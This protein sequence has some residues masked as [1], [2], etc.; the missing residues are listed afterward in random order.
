MKIGILTL[1]D[2]NDNF[3][4][5]LQAWSLK[6]AVTQISP[7]IESGVIPLVYDDQTEIR[8]FKK[9]PQNVSV[10]TDLRR[11]LSRLCRNFKRGIHIKTATVRSNKF[12]DFFKQNSS[13]SMP[14]I[15]AKDFVG[16]ELDIDIFIVGSDWVWHIPERYLNAQPCS[17]GIEYKSV[18]LGFFPLKQNQKL[19]A[20]AASQGIIP[21]IRSSLFEKALDNFATVS[22]REEESIPYLKGCNSNKEITKVV[23]PTLLLKREDFLMILSQPKEVDYIAV[24]CLPFAFREQFREY[25]VNLQNRINKQIIILNMP[26][27]FSIP[28][29]RCVGN[30]IGPREFLGYISGASYLVTNSFHGMVF[31]S[32]FHTKF[33][34]FRRQQQDYRQD[35]LA[36]MLKLEQR[37]LDAGSTIT[38]D[39]DPF[40]KTI[41]WSICDNLRNQINKS[42]WDFLKSS[43]V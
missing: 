27:E 32:I 22:V 2:K 29:C 39:N 18:L 7:T 3:G 40:F 12:N 33:T 36:K 24:Y 10:F 15:C 43:I 25:V 5:H 28:G 34:A 31:S 37:L 19:I 38:H 26:E 1:T 23:D 42:S 8:L 35:N 21:S 16:S 4:A 13:F 6:T 11:N 14:A 30:D 20:Y 41:D 9:Y 17:E